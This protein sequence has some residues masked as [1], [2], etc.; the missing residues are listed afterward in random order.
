MADYAI[1]YSTATGRALRVIGPVVSAEELTPHT[2][3]EGETR[4]I[5]TEAQMLAS[6]PQSLVTAASGKTPVNDR[7]AELDEI[8]NVANTTIIDLALDLPAMPPGKYL[9]HPRA[10]LGWYHENGQWFEPPAPRG[11]PRRDP[12]PR[13]APPRTMRPR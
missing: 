7:F 9:A 11:A 10:G 2:L 4:L 5:V 3:R 12:A 6:D 1:D 8:G 13:A